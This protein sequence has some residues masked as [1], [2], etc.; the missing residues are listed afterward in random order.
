MDNEINERFERIERNLETVGN[1]LDVM[2][3]EGAKI[4]DA[5]T[6]L[7]VVGRTCLDSCTELRAA[8][9]ELRESLRES[10]AHLDDKI[11]I[12]IDTVD[13]FIRRMDERDK[14]GEK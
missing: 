7:I 5:A 10:H 12:L 2:A 8:N 11:N 1:R 4:L 9:A 3:T 13:R 6:K 14:R